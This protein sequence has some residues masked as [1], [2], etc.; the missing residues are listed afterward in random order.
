LS[1]THWRSAHYGIDQ[2]AAQ[3]ELEGESLQI[4]TIEA[5]GFR[6]GTN[7][8]QF[9]DAKLRL[10]GQA[11]TE[12]IAGQAELTGISLSQ[13]Q[14]AFQL[15]IDLTGQI[16][17]VAAIGGSPSQPQ[18][19]GELHLDGVKV[20][21]IAIEPAKIGFSYI[22]RQFHLEHWQSL[23]LIQVVTAEERVDP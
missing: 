20:R 12:M 22:D 13:M 23:P 15:P 19:K 2:I 21:E 7:S 5:A 9:L 17:A 16:Q 18:L 11:T 6:W 14:Q 8:H 4:P 10:Q 1:G 3:F